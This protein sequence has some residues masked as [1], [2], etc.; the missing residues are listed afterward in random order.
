MASRRFRSSEAARSKDK[1]LEKRKASRAGFPPR[2]PRSLPATSSSRETAPG[3]TPPRASAPAPGLK[4]PGSC[5]AG[6]SIPSQRRR[7][8]F[9]RPGPVSAPL[10]P[11]LQG[12]ATLREESTGVPPSGEGAHPA[13][14]AW[15]GA[16]RRLRR[17]P[18]VPRGP[19]FHSPP[20]FPLLMRFGGTGPL[21][22]APPLSFPRL[23]RQGPARSGA[24]AG[25]ASEAFPGA[26]AASSP[27]PEAGRKRQ[28]RGSRRPAAAL[29]GTPQR[30]GCSSVLLAAFG[31]R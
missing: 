28:A 7:G 24:V 19:P 5:A 11:G 9:R 2:E 12:S 18:R 10:P 16:S 22:P 14:L 23:Q 29:Q 15:H 20:W 26:A 4:P 27:R 25:Q 21:P 3:S 31:S 13:H 30:R 8:H 17:P 6:T 1:R